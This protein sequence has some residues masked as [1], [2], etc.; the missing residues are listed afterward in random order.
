MTLRT[1]AVKTASTDEP[2]TDQRVLDLDSAHPVKVSGGNV[3][4]VDA[5]ESTADGNA[6]KFAGDQPVATTSVY[7]P[8]DLRTALREA[9]YERN[10]ID[11]ALENTLSP[12]NGRE[13]AR[14]AESR[15]HGHDTELATD[16]GRETCDAGTTAVHACETC[17]GFAHGE[18]D[19][20][21]ECRKRGVSPIDDTPL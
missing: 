18:H 15:T 7:S 6:L 19:Q 2:T 4:F 12:E 21:A 14:I 13:A 5:Y 3:V 20:C 1:H 17:D 10:H 8:R 11:F 16:G 9:G